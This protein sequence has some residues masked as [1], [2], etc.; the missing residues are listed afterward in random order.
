VDA[1]RAE[2]IAAIKSTWS[3]KFP[4][5]SLDAALIR[6]FRCSDMTFMAEDVLT[7]ILAAI[8]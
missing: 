4:K 5:E 6:R 1:S 7:N 3:E 8:A 2:I